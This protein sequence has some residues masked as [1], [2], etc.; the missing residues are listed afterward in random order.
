MSIS[1]LKQ[2]YETWLE[3]EKVEWDLA[4][5]L[6]APNQLRVAERGFDEYWLQKKLMHYFNVLDRRLFKTKHRRHQIRMQRLVVL[7]HAESV[8]WHAHVCIV[9][10]QHIQQ[11][12]LAAAMH[13]LWLKHMNV[14]NTANTA[15]KDKL[16]WA[17]PI[18]GNYQ[19]YTLLNA[20]ELSGI[21]SG[22]HYGTEQTTQGTLDI[23]NCHF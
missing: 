17:E 1:S 19:S 4:I 22:T 23:L 18:S 9:T 8:G 2:A 21:T 14:K 16:F 6:H 12:K 20:T 11:D 13:L 3:A 7:G 15:F 10:P 5:S